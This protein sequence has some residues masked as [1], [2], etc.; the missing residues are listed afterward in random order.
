[1]STPITSLPI[2]FWTLGWSSLVR[3][4]RAGELRLLMLAV[5][6]AVA[7]LSAVG[8]FADRLQGGLSRDARALIGGDVV[9]SSDNTPPPA[10]EAQ[11]RELGLTVAQTLNF[12]TM[13]RA[14]EAEGG[15]ARLVALKSV[16]E[17]Y[18][19]RGSLRV[20]ETPT[21][22]D[23]PTR[24]IPA[25]G[26]AWVDEALLVSLNLTLE[27]FEGDADVCKAFFAAHNGRPRRMQVGEQFQEAPVFPQ[28]PRTGARRCDCSSNVGDLLVSRRVGD[29]G[30]IGEV[31]AAH[32]AQHL[33]H[34]GGSAAVAHGLDA[35][36]R[37]AGER[38]EPAADDDPVAE[39][40]RALV[41]DF[42]AGDAAGD[43]VLTGD[44]A[45]LAVAG[46]A[47]DEIGWCAIDR[48]ASTLDPAQHAFVRNV[49]EQQ[50]AA[51]VEPDGTLGPSAAGVKLI[52]AGAGHEQVAEAGVTDLVMRVFHGTILAGLQVLPALRVVGSMMTAMMMRPV[53]MRRMPAPKP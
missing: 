27:A 48:D 35:R 28:V 5:T 17:G 42:G 45:A 36:G 9:I 33:Q 11:A 34:I 23:A 13:G 41:I 22:P 43:R 31:Q 19:L 15:A 21:T 38:V 49:A 53:R 4:W 2:R 26:T 7:A 39:S 51:I 10:F 16:G 6:L 24:E 29:G 1:M 3:D 50:I 25:P 20:A 32:L 47:V 46:V 30:L 8:F 37:G 52:Q 40:G 12:P 14:R 18:P 44:Q